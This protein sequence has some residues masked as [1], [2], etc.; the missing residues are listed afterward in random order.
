MECFI[1]EL[2]EI[3]KMRDLGDAVEI[4]TS[5]GTHT[6]PKACLRYGFADEQQL[7]VLQ[8]SGNNRIWCSSWK[9]ICDW[10]EKFHINPATVP[11]PCADCNGSK[12]RWCEMH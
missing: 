5:A 9:Q 11:S 7:P 6:I 4:K 10:L 1:A 8:N 3:I 12:C 2:E